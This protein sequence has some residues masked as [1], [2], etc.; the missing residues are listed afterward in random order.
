M[1]ESTHPRP[2][3]ITVRVG[4]MISPKRRNSE[5]FQ[6]THL[7]NGNCPKSLKTSPERN[8]N[9]YTFRRFRT[10]SRRAI[11]FEAQ[12]Q[13]KGEEKSN[14]DNPTFKNRRK[15]MNP[16]DITFSNRYKNTTFASPHF[17]PADPGSQA[18]F[19]LP[20]ALGWLARNGS[21][22]DTIDFQRR[23]GDNSGRERATAA[24]EGIE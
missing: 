15:L 5:Y 12:E 20:P 2:I 18:Q 23:V 6:S 17:R 14:R 10:G 4:G 19:H 24:P 13:A 7:A 16:N 22:I 21:M 8:F 1:T 11:S 3:L 9:R